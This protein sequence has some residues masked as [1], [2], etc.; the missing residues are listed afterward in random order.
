MEGNVGDGGCSVFGGNEFWLIISVLIFMYGGLQKNGAFGCALISG[1]SKEA[2][3]SLVKTN[4]NRG[5]R[6]FSA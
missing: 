2:A 4:K 3:D 1:I 6:V 5:D